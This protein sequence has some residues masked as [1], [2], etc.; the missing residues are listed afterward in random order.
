MTPR[1]SDLKPNN[2]LVR[3]EDVLSIIADEM[4]TEPA[5]TETSQSH[6][7]PA[8]M[9]RCKSQ[10]LPPWI[11]AGDHVGIVPLHA[12]LVDFGEGESIG[13]MLRGFP[14]SSS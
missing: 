3:P 11:G 7:Y 13:A 1:A 8:G 10:P 9:I 2:A 12:V 6:R 14:H 4:V 5:V